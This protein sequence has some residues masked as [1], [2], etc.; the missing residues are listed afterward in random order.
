[1]SFQT[2]LQ[3]LGA[4]AHLDVSAAAQAGGCTIRFDERME[5]VFEHDPPQDAVQVF[6]TV[7]QVAGMLPEQRGKLFEALLQ[8]HLLGLATGGCHFGWDPQL[9]RVLLFRTIA[10]AQGDAAAV[11][12]VEAFVHQ[13]ERWQAR[14]LDYVSRQAGSG[15]PPAP[16]VMQRV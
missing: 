14:L 12:A 8:L 2:F 15:A 6:A 1:M 16:A 13:L 4:A 7:L 11:A 5:V 9:S 3:A 10:L